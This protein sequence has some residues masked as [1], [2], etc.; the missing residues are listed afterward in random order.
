MSSISVSSLVLGSLTVEV[1]GSDST[2][3]LSVLGTAP[4]VLSVELGTPGAQGPA[5]TIAVGTTTTLSP[6]A[7]ATVVNAGTSSA[8]V[9]N[10]GIPAGLKGDT[11]NTGATGSAATIAVGSTSTGA[12]GSSASVVNSGTSSAAVFDFTIP[13]GDKGDKGD[14]GNTGATGA[15]GSPGAAATVTAGTTT[16]GAPGTSATVVNAGTTSAAVFNFTIPRGDV[17]ATGATG[18]T[19]PAGPGVPVGGTAG[20]SLLKVDGTDYNTTWGTPPLA[21][22]ATSSE[23]VIATVRNAT[24]STLTAGQ[25]V[26]INGA[27]GNRPSVALARADLEATSSG[28]YGMVSAPIANNSDGII[29]IAG[30]VANLNTSA[31]TDGDLLY[32]SPTV[33]GGF[34]STKPTAPDNLVYVGVVTRSHPTL[35]VVQLRISNGFELDE[36]HDVAATTP[37]NSDLLAFETSTNLWKNKSAA[38]LGLATTSASNATYL[39]KASNLSDLAGPLSTART[40]LGLGTAAVEPA[41]KLVPTGGTTGQ[42]LAK[43]SNTN[44]DLTWATAGGGGSDVQA[45]KTPGTY[46][47]TKPA[48]AKAVFV[49]VAAGGGGG[50]GGAVNATNGIRGGGGGGG[51][52]GFTQIWMNAD[53]LPST[54]TVTVGAGGAGGASRPSGSAQSGLVGQAGG[55]TTF[56][57]FLRAAPGAAGFQGTVANGGSGGGG[58][59]NSLFCFYGLTVLGAGSGGVGAG[60]A[61]NDIGTSQPLAAQGGGGGAGAAANVTTAANGGTGGG[62]LYNTA[63]SGTAAAMVG[64]AGGVGSTATAA[65]AGTNAYAF[66]WCGTGGGGGFYRTATNGG[67]GGAGGA[68]A[69]GGGGGG[70]SD[71]SNA[72]GAGGAGGPGFCLVITT[73]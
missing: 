10:F 66:G 46:T 65:V 43:A 8:A 21:T 14:T 6:G 32:L 15:T 28:T 54:V 70:G 12:A 38:T 73:L 26:Y 29:V 50:G 67:T 18:A 52:G 53:D 72:S 19:G 69:G 55:A 40:N 20:Q 25:V 45:Y 64:G 35:G 47:W 58:S 60:T 57:S 7:A 4:A 17:G 44:W 41:T 5:A 63:Q 56:G 27:I 9:F 2:L 36:L 61:G 22:L 13:R 71:V 3:A 1:E 16:T 31:Y 39:A 59:N 48:G 68:P 23:T 49:F 33:A 34:T 51:G 37:S 30:Y 62:K 11:G 42:V 24:G